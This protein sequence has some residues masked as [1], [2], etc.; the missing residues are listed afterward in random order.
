[1]TGR[2]TPLDI[3]RAASKPALG[4]RYKQGPNGHYTLDVEP[5]PQAAVLK[6]RFYWTYRCEKCGAEL[7][8]V[9]ELPKHLARHGLDGGP[10]IRCLGDVVFVK[11]V[12]R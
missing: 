10:R 12:P 9:V 3:Y 6:E 4:F 11:K 8:Y 5:D 2:K 1:M 7:E